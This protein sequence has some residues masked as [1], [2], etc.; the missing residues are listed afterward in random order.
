MT[1]P[2]T[3]KLDELFRTLPRISGV[4]PWLVESAK[5]EVDLLKFHAGSQ[6]HN[7]KQVNIAY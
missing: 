1:G 4:D 5:T 3:K 2:Q 6:V 7:H